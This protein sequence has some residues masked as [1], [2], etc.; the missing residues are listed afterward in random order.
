MT[1]SGKFPSPS[2][3]QNVIVIVGGFGSGKSEVSVNLAR[4]LARSGNQVS[5]ADLDIVNP[6][7]RSRETAVALA[8]MGIKSLIPEGAY[9]MADLPIIVPEVKTAI[10]R[11]QGKLILDVGG[12]DTGARVLS[13]L[14]DAFTP[15]RYE[16]LLVLNAYRPFTADVAGTLRIME[17]IETAG[18][19][20]FTG[21]ISNSHLIEQ[22]TVA[23]VLH[24][25]NLTR[26]VSDETGLPVAFVS[27]V[28]SVVR[29]LDP[30]KI[31][32]PV[33][34][35]DRSLLKPWERSASA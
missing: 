18:K 22:T 30:G 12:D 17:E 23:E 5:I 25:L 9:A 28:E 35:I 34:A 26:Q 14:A 2:F 19:L 1:D 24:G 16:L 32:C 11:A 3:S 33:L 4:L 15:G 13:S 29:Q 6:Y 8:A 31:P 21:L 20:K 7:F 10:Q 27:A